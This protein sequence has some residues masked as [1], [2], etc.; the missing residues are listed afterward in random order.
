[1][2]IKITD[3]NGG[4]VP[5][6]KDAGSVKVIFSATND[7]EDASKYFTLYPNPTNQKTTLRFDPEAINVKAVTLFDAQGKSVLQQANDSQNGF[8]ELDVADFTSG[9]YFLKINTKEKVF[10]DKLLIIK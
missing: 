9:L 10:I 5:F 8:I 2:P 3:K 1:L 4:S 7:I 6:A